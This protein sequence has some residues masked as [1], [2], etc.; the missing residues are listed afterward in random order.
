MVGS[1][2]F[3]GKN[4]L[5]PSTYFAPLTSYYGKL[6]GGGVDVTP[7]VGHW[8]INPLQ[9][10]GFILA[11]S[12]APYPA[13]DGSGTCDSQVGNFQLEIHYFAAP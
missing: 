12:N 2:H 3:H 13:V 4:V 5:M 9:N 6:S 11:P 7:A 10:F 1:N 8:L